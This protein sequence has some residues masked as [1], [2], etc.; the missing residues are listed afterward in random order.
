VVTG[1][2]APEYRRSY[3]SAG[4]RKATFEQQWAQSFPGLNVSQVTVSDTTK[5]EEPFKL[6]FAM[7][8][9]RFAEVLPLG[10]RFF[11]LGAGRAFTQVLAPLG[12]RKSDVELPGVWTNRFK[13]TYEPPPGFTVQGVPEPFDETN[14]CG[15]AMLTVKVE[16]GR[17][18]VTAE[19]TMSKARI[20]PSEYPKFRAWLL[21]VDQA[22]S[23]KLTVQG[24][25]GQSAQR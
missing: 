4:T 18:V 25:G 2:G 8:A 9:P 6:Q 23:R 10:L 12:E 20:T 21:R 16:N 17:P 3:Q 22:F 5:L 24:P 11:P 14:D 15:R 1:Q 13:I 7:K 19:V